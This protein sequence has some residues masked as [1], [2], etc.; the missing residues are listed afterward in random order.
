MLETQDNYRGMPIPLNKSITETFEFFQA[1]DNFT[2]TF[3][4]RKNDVVLMLADP[5]LDRRVIDAIRGHA[6]ARGAQFRVYMEQSSRVES[7]DEHIKPLLEQAT[8][9]V[10]TWF[11]SIIAP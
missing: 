4:F 9:V 5:L 2:R 1:L 8:F 10:S 3:A 6:K 7:I 11:C